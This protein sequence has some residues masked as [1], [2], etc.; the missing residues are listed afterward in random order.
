MPNAIAYLMLAAWPLVTVLLFRRLRRGPAL[1]WSLVAGYLLLPPQ[2]AAF[3]FPLLPPFNKLMIAHLSLLAALLLVAGR[4]RTP[5]GGGWRPGAWLPDSPVIRGLLA[6][7]VLSP[8]LTVLANPEPLVFP[9]RVIPG[10]GARDALALT[11][12]QGLMLIGFLLARRL[13]RDPAAPRAL[14]VALMLSGLAYSLPMLLEIR[15]SPQVNRWVYGFY[16]HDFSQT[17]RGGGYRPLVFLPHG[18]WA[19]LFLL[20]SLIAAL[21]LW[22]AERSETHPRLLLAALWLGGVL[23]LAKSLG[24]LLFAALLV[25]VLVLGGV[26]AQLRIAAALGVLA[27][28]YPVLKAAEAVP[29]QALLQQAEKIDSERAGSL[30]FRFANEDLLFERASRKPLTGWGS[31]GRNQIRDPVSGE[32]TSISDGRWII[33]LGQFGW[34][35]FVAEFGLLVLP[36]LLLWREARALPPGS[37]PPL[38]GPLALLLGINLID[39]L[40][41]AT[42]TPLTWLV[43]GAVLG[44]AERL[45]ARRRRAA[46][47]RAALLRRHPRTVI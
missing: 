47:L 40:P 26:R 28:A 32:I 4:E 46:G 22:R 34:F 25:P 29:A 9:L 36:L 2:P 41:N 37:A 21:G 5:P 1:I 19:A 35:G 15:L 17:L 27:L 45:R 11:I 23:V 3:D 8:V 39:L 30:R 14:L 16:Q 43:A 31:W 42:L 20:S 7:F 6:L 33:V 44:Q 18:L 10:L 12:T 13:L 38:L 24:A